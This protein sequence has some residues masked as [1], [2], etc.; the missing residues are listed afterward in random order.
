MAKRKQFTFYESFYKALVKLPVELAQ[1][2]AWIIITYALT[3][4][5]PETELEPA[6]DVAFTLIKPVLDTARN[7]AEAISASNKRRAK[8]NQSDPNAVPMDVQSVSNIAQEKE[9]E[10]E[11]EKEVEVENE[12]E[13]EEE[14]EK[15]SYLYISSLS[16]ETAGED[17]ERF[18][19]LYPIQLGKQQAW[20]AWQADPPD[21]RQ[22]ETAI[23]CWKRSRQWRQ[24]NGRFIPRAE[25]FL[26]EKHY[27]DL[28][29]DSV[30]MGASGYLGKAELEAIERL[31]NGNG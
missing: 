10:V 8:K 4:Q 29:R 12:V 11:N 6:L 31:M 30:P 3:G 17:F 18:W 14:I 24:E 20:E 5:L 2:G 23:R 26:K 16:G 15:E 13:V 25:K 28:P 27:L 22:M 21:M 9:K 7:K 19:N 1:Q